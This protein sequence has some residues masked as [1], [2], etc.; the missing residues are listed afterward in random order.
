MTRC[1][2]AAHVE[3]RHVLSSSEMARRALEDPTSCHV[4][5][6]PSKVY[7][8]GANGSTPEC[9]LGC[10]LFR[11]NVTVHSNADP[12]LDLVRNWTRPLPHVNHSV[13]V[14]PRGPAPWS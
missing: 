9:R 6:N 3:R 2:N 7:H 8:Y 13:P 10:T 12:R 4:A 14:V 11:A 5:D 1:V